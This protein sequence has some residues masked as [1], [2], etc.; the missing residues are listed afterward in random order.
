MLINTNNIIELSNLDINF[1]LLD[2]NDNYFINKNQLIL[3]NLNIGNYKLDIN[4]NKNKINNTIKYEIIIEP[5]LIYNNIIR[6]DINNIPLIKPMK[7]FPSNGIFKINSSKFT[8]NKYG[9]IKQITPNI[10]NYDIIIEYVVNNI[11]TITNI[12]INID[13]FVN[14]SKLT[15]ESIYG[16]ILNI[17]K[18]SVNPVGLQF[19]LKSTSDLITINKSG[20]IIINEKLPIDKYYLQIEYG[21]SITELIIIIKSQLFYNENNITIPYGLNY[22][23]YPTVSYFDGEFYLD[24]N[25]PGLTIDQT[26]GVIDIT[27]LE[28][29]NYII[30]VYY[31]FNNVITLFLLYINIILNLNYE[32]DSYLI[33]YNSD[34]FNIIPIYSPPGGTFK[35]T[36]KIDNIVIDKKTGI[37]NITNA[38]IG[39]NEILVNY[40][41]KNILINKKISID[42]LPILNYEISNYTIYEGFEFI[43]NTPTINPKGGK[44][45]LNNKDNKNYSISLNGQITIFNTINLGKYELCVTYIYNQITVTNII[46]INVIPFI[47]YKNIKINLGEHIIIKPYKHNDKYKYSIDNDLLTIDLLGN[48][49]NISKLLVGLYNII[50]SVDYDNN[51][52]KCLLKI[53]IKPIL[54]YENN[55][56]F[57]NPSDGIFEYDKN[58]LEIINNKINI[59]SN[60]YTNYKSKITYVCN[61]I[62]KSLQIEYMIKPNKLY[63]N[64]IYNFNY[65]DVIIIKPLVNRGVYKCNNYK[66][67]LDSN[68][69][70]NFRNVEIGNFI[71]IITW[72]YE[73]IKLCDTININ[74]FPYINYDT[75]RIEIIGNNIF[76]SNEPVILPEGGNFSIITDKTNNLF[77][78]NKTG[79]IYI[80]TITPKS[81]IVDI[82][83]SKNNIYAKTS[84][85]IVSKPYISWT[86]SDLTL[87]YSEEYKITDLKLWP[88]GG[89]LSSNSENIIITENNE[90]IFQNFNIGKYSIIIYYEFNNIKNNFSIN[91]LIKPLCIYKIN[92]IKKYYYEIIKLDPP[93]LSHL[94]GIFTISSDTLNTDTLNFNTS[95]GALEINN[96]DIGNYK[97]NIIYTELTTNIQIINKITFNILPYLKYSSDI[98]IIYSA[99]YIENS[100]EPLYYPLNGNFKLLYP[101]ENI[102][103]NPISGIITVVDLPVGIYEIIV[104]YN[105]KH[106]KLFIK[107]KVK[108][109]VNPSI[110]YNTTLIRLKFG[111]KF[112]SMKP[113]INYEGGIFYSNALPFGCIVNKTDGI[114]SINDIIPVANYTLLISYKVNDIIT[115]TNINLQIL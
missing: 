44:F 76:Y 109:L 98:N 77:K 48:I 87:N 1:K 34:S 21:S 68:G 83:Y 80:K 11:K 85:E 26:Y 65:N 70:I 14:W 101:N 111:S 62:S 100:I 104:I 92:N 4:Y 42:I 46:Y 91:L 33:N 30:T 54:R 115:T 93:L 69:I 114:I 18:P 96:V 88:H 66:F 45:K 40:N 78:I 73:N 41:Y 74:I 72:E 99:K 110:N 43:I 23:L 71:L 37:I 97:I 7:Y 49:L 2:K 22:K 86:Q 106:K 39:I 112:I 113:T 82:T 8:I 58:C 3:S 94:D 59:I 47:F 24:T 31:N 52:Y 35:L 103:L 107:N 67:I 29:Y 84:I 5:I 38:N 36:N 81:Y 64:S 89:K 61:N 10:G 57:T 90:L 27:N 53:I 63:E 60:T 20:S 16:N 55:I 75:S 13:P 105:I 32:K 102:N 95:T 12:N 17:E 6:Y 56:L 79:N 15:F 51:I 9:E 28:P 50:I 19:I 25:I 108:I